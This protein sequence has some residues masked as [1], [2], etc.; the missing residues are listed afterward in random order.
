MTFFYCSSTFYFTVLVDGYEELLRVVKRTIPIIY[1]YEVHYLRRF[2]I[3]WSLLHRRIYQKL[4]YIRFATVVLKCLVELKKKEEDDLFKRYLSF[5]VDFCKMDYLWEPVWDKLEEYNSSLKQLDRHYQVGFFSKSFELLQS[6]SLPIKQGI[7]P[8]HKWAAHENRELV[9]RNI[10]QHIRKY[11][12]DKIRSNFHFTEKCDKCSNDLDLHENI[13]ECVTCSIAGPKRFIKGNSEIKQCSKCVNITGYCELFPGKKLYDHIA[14][15]HP[16][17]E[18]EQYY[19]C[20]SDSLGSYHISWAIF[21]QIK[22]RRAYTFRTLDEKYFCYDCKEHTC[23]I[24]R[25]IINNKITKNLSN[26]LIDNYI[27]I[28]IAPSEVAPMMT[29]IMLYISQL[30]DDPKCIDKEFEEDEIL[31]YFWTIVVTLF[32]KCFKDEINNTGV[33]LSLFEIAG[34]DIRLKRNA[35]LGDEDSI[36]IRSL[37]YKMGTSCDSI[38]PTR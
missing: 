9:W 34:K 23:W 22:S 16:K 6:D 1:E 37:L 27:D 17:D 15:N 21:K 14:K 3:Y 31:M 33:N 19:D 13:C 36:L 28:P 26:Y 35:I 32:A 25:K 30:Y 2:G 12:P 38:F 7:I 18:T 8:P 29:E 11:L 20:E 10:L 24:A 5:D 4:V